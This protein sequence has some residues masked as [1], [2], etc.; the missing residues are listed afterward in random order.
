MFI[1][2]KGHWKIVWNFPFAW[3]SV[4]MLKLRIDKYKKDKL[5]QT[6]RRI[7]ALYFSPGLNLK[8]AKQI[9]VVSKSDKQKHKKQWN[10][11]KNKITTTTTTTLT[12][13]TSTTRTTTTKLLWA[14]YTSPLH[15]KFSSFYSFLF[16]FSSFLLSFP[17]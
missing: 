13:T 4:I 15:F 11:I 3:I 14:F 1:F 5:I 12:T 16:V 7:Q 17:G 8:S 9:V 2:L 6:K 10:K